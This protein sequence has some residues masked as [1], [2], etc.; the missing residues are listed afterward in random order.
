[1][2]QLGGAGLAVATVILTGSGDAGAYCKG[3]ADV[4]ASPRVLPET[5]RGAYPEQQAPRDRA[6]GNKALHA[7]KLE[8]QPQVCVALGFSKTKPRAS[9][10][11]W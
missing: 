1:M 9:R 5:V 11:S 8:P 7:L 6:S 4:G 2:S 3:R 10:P